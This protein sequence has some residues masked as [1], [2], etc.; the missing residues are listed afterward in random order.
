LAVCRVAEEYHQLNYIYVVQ[1]EY[2]VLSYTAFLLYHILL[3]Q[4][5]AVATGKDLSH[6]PVIS[7]PSS[8]SIKDCFLISDLT[9]RGTYHKK[10]L[11]AIYALFKR[12]K[13]FKLKNEEL[14]TTFYGCL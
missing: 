5:V 13:G 10:F 6:S 14:C 4:P 2:S 7:Y 8:P 1:V 11:G 12:F 9:N 3:I